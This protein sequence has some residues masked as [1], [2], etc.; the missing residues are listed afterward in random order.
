MAIFK[1]IIFDLGKVVFDLSFDRVF[2][3][4]ATSSESHFNNIKNKFS[5]DELFDMFE[6][7][8]ITPERFREK[9]SQRLGI[10]ISDD[11][12]D[13]GWCDLYL[14][15]YK[16]IDNLLITLKHKYKL[17]A[18]TNTNLIHNKVWNIKYADTLQHFEKIFS[19]HETGTRKPEEKSFRIALDYLQCKP[20]ETIFLDDNADNINGA[21]KLGIATILVSSQEKMKS[22]LVANGLLI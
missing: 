3:S 13:K 21:A 20:K 6:R 16:D 7:N 15:V 11:E 4:W 2:Q 9:I 8:E 17:V 14:D 10:N 1:S 12:F 22:E 5:F 19:S 18:L